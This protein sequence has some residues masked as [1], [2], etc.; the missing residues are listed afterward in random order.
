MSDRRIHWK[1]ASIGWASPGHA[2]WVE[3]NLN[4][5][6]TL[7]LESLLRAWLDE[8]DA[9]ASADV[10][11]FPMVMNDQG[12]RFGSLTITSE[13]L[14]QFD[15][16]KLR[17]V[18]EDLTTGAVLKVAEQVDIEEQLRDQFLAVLR[19]PKSAAGE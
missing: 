6:E 13:T 10:S 7:L 16:A 18:I 17:D 3:H 19:A 8:H 5:R 11:S 9:L 12:T 4:E 14:L 2:L 1:T 15:A